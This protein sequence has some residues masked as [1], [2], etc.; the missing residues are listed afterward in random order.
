MG[1]AWVSKKGTY[2]TYLSR[3]EHWLGLTTK[4]PSLL[5]NLPPTALCAG[6]PQGQ[7]G[8]WL[9]ADKSFR[10]STNSVTSPPVME[11]LCD[12]ICTRH[13]RGTK[14]LV[15]LE[16]LPVIRQERTWLCSATI[17]CYMTCLCCNIFHLALKSCGVT[18]IV[19]IR[20]WQG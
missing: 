13:D 7:A 11:M 10:Q 17:G 9:W 1:L 8:R 5:C 3:R 16:A 19:I 20:H 14:I 12:Q 4:T 15:M 6:D 2:E 18:T